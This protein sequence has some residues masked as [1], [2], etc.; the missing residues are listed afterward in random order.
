MHGSKHICG[1]INLVPCYVPLSVGLSVGS[2]GEGWRARAER[3]LLQDDIM[4]VSFRRS[5]ERDKYREGAGYKT[6][7][8][9]VEREQ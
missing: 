9:V 8:M 5:S 1:L 2:R 6:P 4:A 3:R 7:F